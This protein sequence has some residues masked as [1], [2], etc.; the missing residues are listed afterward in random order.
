MRK[1]QWGGKYG[2]R[3]AA[4]FII[5]I[6]RA[7]HKLF[8]FLPPAMD[9]PMSSEMTLNRNEGTLCSGRNLTDVT[10]APPDDMSLGGFWHNAVP[11]RSDKV[12]E[13][14]YVVP[15]FM[16]NELG[17]DPAHIFEELLR[18]PKHP[19]DT[20]IEF[21]PQ[22]PVLIEGDHPALKYRGN[23]IKRHKLWAQTDIDDGCA[24][25]G[26]T[27]W[28]WKIAMATKDI[29][30]VPWLDRV[31]IA[32]NRGLEKKYN[33]YICTLYKNGADNIGFHHDKARD[34]D[35]DGW[36]VILKVGG[37]AR[38][39]Q[40]GEPRGDGSPKIVWSK[41]LEPGTAVFMNAAGNARVKHGVPEDESAGPS[42]SIVARCIKTIIPWDHVFNRAT[43]RVSGPIEGAPPAK[44]VRR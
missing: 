13:G 22:S 4:T 11:A 2:G 12:C 7:L 17:V 1:V 5:I 36:V 9:S 20:P 32:L 40:F 25:Y 3:L 41:F 26:Y 15:N 33:H 8:A 27:G 34:F 28:Q 24:R 38:R 42:G 39:F 19:S 35:P 21:E 10:A 30:S 37:S 43:K 44:C 18:V 31:R 23:A 14:V 16:Q 29:E 6:Y